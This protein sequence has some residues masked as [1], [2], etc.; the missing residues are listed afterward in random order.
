[1]LLAGS[2]VYETIWQNRTESE[3]VMDQVERNLFKAVALNKRIAKRYSKM[4]YRNRDS[5]FSYAVYAYWV[6]RDCSLSNSLIKEYLFYI[7]ERLRVANTSIVML[8]ISLERSSI[9]HVL[10]CTTNVRGKLGFSKKE[11][12]ESDIG[13]LVP[14]F[15]QNFHANAIERMLDSTTDK[16]EVF[17][18]KKHSVC[19][20][21]EG[22]LIEFKG[23][24]RVLPILEKLSV[25]GYVQLPQRK[26]RDYWL[27]V[28]KATA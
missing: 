3:L 18:L 9:G 19:S 27:A 2:K 21:S 6:M 11:L 14:S 25:I 15:Y 24:F 4:Q 1:M 28:D 17:D 7:H 23:R 5:I 13:M 26:Y 22:E 16:S 8:Q 10:N 12:L 20:N